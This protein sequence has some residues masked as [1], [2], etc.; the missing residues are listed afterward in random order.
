MV[1]TESLTGDARRDMATNQLL[2]LCQIRP[3]SEQTA[4]EAAR[5]RTRTGRAGE[6]SAVDAVVAALGAEQGGEGLVLTA[7]IGDL[8]DLCQ[9]SPTPVAVGPV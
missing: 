9:H 2:G 5:L 4:R 6:I 7:D 3:V 8:R 1:L